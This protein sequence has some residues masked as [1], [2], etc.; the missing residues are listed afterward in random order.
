MA[1]ERQDRN[2]IE[3]LA[4][5]FLAR[6]RR[7]EHPSVSE[8]VR[9]H[10]ELA[11]EIRDLFPALVVMEEIG[12]DE[13]DDSVT[14]HSDDVSALERIGDYRIIREIGRGGMG[15]VYE[16]EQESLG[17]QVALK[18]LPHRL[19]AEPTSLERFRREAR[20]AARLHHT[21]IVPVFEVGEANGV[22]YYAMQYIEGQGLDDVL[23]ELR[24]IRRNPTPPAPPSGDMAVPE[25]SRTPS[26]L[27]VSI[28]DRLSR[29]RHTPATPAIESAA[30][31]SS[32]LQGTSPE[33]D[34]APAPNGH[35]MPGVKTG[36]GVNGSSHISAKSDWQY[37]RNVARVGQQ[38]AEALAYAHGQGVLHRDIK[39]SNLLVDVHGIVWVT[40]FGL[41]KEGGADLTQTG[42]LVGTLS[43]MAP[44][45]F[46]GVSEPRSD[47]Y[48]LGLTLYEM[49]TLEPAFKESDRGRLIM[50]ITHDEPVRPARID[51]RVA[52][53]LETIVLKAI[54]KEPA[55][56]YASADALAEDLRRFLADRPIRARRASL[57]EQLLR[58]GRRNPAVALLLIAVGVLMSM[59]MVVLLIAYTRLNAELGKTASAEEAER[60]ARDDAVEQLWQSLRAEAQARRHSRRAGDIVLALD[61]IDKAGKIARESGM[62]DDRFRELQTEAIACLAAPD[63]RVAQEWDGL[64]AGRAVVDFDDRLERCVWA[65]EP[66]GEVRIY[67]GVG[68]DLEFS[69]QSGFGTSPGVAGCRPELSRDGQFL[70]LSNESRVNPRVQLWRLTAPRPV[71]LLDLDARYMTFR[72]D[73]RLFA[74]CDINGKLV[75]YDLPSV[76]VR[77]RVENAKTVRSQAV[78]LH[79][80]RPLVAIGNESGVEVIDLSTGK[81]ATHWTMPSVES[82]AWHPDGTVL[83]AAGED[84]IVR[85]WRSD[86]LEEVARLKGILNLGIRLAFNHAG[87]LLASSSWASDLRLWDPRTA[88]QVLSTRCESE[89]ELRFHEND[90]ALAGVW[91]GLR[92]RTWEI[93][94]SRVRQA[95]V[96]E[97]GS[98]LPIGMR[99]SVH[100]S[101]RWVAA[102]TSVGFGIWDLKTGKQL[103]DV[104]L[105]DAGVVLCH[106]SDELLVQGASG[107]YRWAVQL[108]QAQT[109]SITIG[110]PQRLP[111]PATVWG[112]LASSQDGNVVA[113]APHR[114][115]L[116]WHRDRPNQT[117]HLTPHFDARYV[118]VHPDGRWV[119]TGSHNGNG[120]RI[121]DAKTRQLVRELVPDEGW[122][123]VEFSPDGQW[124]A[125]RGLSIRLWHVSSWQPGPTFECEKLMA[126]AFA[127]NGRWLAKATGTGA[128]RLVDLQSGKELA[129]L[130]HPDQHVTHTIAF[131]PDS[132]KIFATVYGETSTFHVWDLRR[133]RDELRRMNLDRGLALDF[134]PEP[135][136][137]D[138]ATLS[139][140]IIGNDAGMIAKQH[141]EQAKFNV[142]RYRQ[143]WRENP[144]SA[145]VCNDLA[146]A[147]VTAPPTVRDPQEMLMTA[148]KAAQIQPHS[149]LYQGTLGAAYYRTGHYQEAVATLEPNTAKSTD[150]QLAFDLYYLAMSWHHLKDPVKARFYFTWADRWSHAQENVSEQ[151]RQQI[152]ELRAE[153]AGLLH[154]EES[155]TSKS[156]P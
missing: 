88:Q 3:K 5:S 105:A 34:A 155:E 132:A 50:R 86:T 62:S 58:W 141:A 120:A 55:R 99:C 31:R 73:N 67:R 61:A 104:P 129:E 117:T 95:C 112:S 59:F 60:T 45:R 91:D 39:P 130:E 28:A 137:P 30:H 32:Q 80:T 113:S 10:P 40:D 146:W 18:I 100:P 78:A 51:R 69:I 79:P 82:L 11:D 123:G 66:S 81:T 101:G 19:S 85:L 54:A 154:I 126:F 68:G 149:A 57:G 131:G 89:P 151:V 6:Y 107:L 15:I 106:R 133:I 147:H 35:S 125:T 136:S 148:K 63:L 94:P 97:N 36:S 2:P 1:N 118:S 44:E 41:A 56:R 124:L 20:S 150:P 37:Y 108:D 21:N 145:E 110:P 16:A 43:Y 77:Y 93:I 12:K 152:H 13:A 153:A 98:V 46:N 25:Q 17:R 65:G 48:S 29:G 71:K 9:R 33:P 4:D 121:W 27:R 8:Y 103:A 109:G 47:V 75:A 102:G 23:R 7:G 143:A 84:K 72:S 96:E 156:L 138:E 115:A 90:R 122:V 128:I 52:R 134:P 49:L 42:D 74:A 92:L 116:V 14:T 114:G 111:I 135:K 140:H 127:P 144:D 22:H 139:I 26:D 119:A 70:A 53:D 38:V 83:A 87:D 24:R 76:R 64:P 142:E